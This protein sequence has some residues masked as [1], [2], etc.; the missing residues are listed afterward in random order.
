[1]LEKLMQRQNGRFIRHV[2]GIL[3]GGP[4]VETSSNPKLG[5]ATLADP[6]SGRELE[7][8]EL[9]ATGMTNQQIADELVVSVDTVKKH[10]SHIFGKLDAAT[11][12]QAVARARDLAIAVAACHDY[13]CAHQRSQFE[14]PFAPSLNRPS[15]IASAS[16]SLAGLC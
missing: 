6:L 11:R 10:V 8:L 12:T 16:M 5:S 13:V 1:L 15:P 7:V 2:H 4:P 14:P 3:R 9:L